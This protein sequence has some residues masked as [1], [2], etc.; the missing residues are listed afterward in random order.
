MIA[1]ENGSKLCVLGSS[2]IFTENANDMVSGR[3]AKLFQGVVSELVTTDEHQVAGV[4]IPVKDYSVSSI[5]VSQRAIL[6]YGLLWGIAMPLVC[7]VAG[8]VIW[9]KRRKR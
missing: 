8:V 1:G 3:N 5:T 6:V 7:I 2:Y 9:A 4:V